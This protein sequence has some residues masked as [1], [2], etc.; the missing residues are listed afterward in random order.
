VGANR[1][2]L[3]RYFFVVLGLLVLVGGLGVV[4]ACQIRTLVAYGDDMKRAGPMPEAVGSDV[5]VAQ[6]WE[7]TRSA[8]GTVTGV[9]SV[10]VANEVAGIVTK[11]AF[12]S[13]DLVKAGQVLVELDVRDERAQLEAAEARRDLARLTAKRSRALVEAGA[14]PRSQL[15]QHETEL[16]AAESEVTALQAR[17]N[18]NVVRAPFD[19]R[20]GI[21]EVKLGQF[22]APGTRVTTI[23]SLGDVFVDFT[24]PQEQLQQVGVGY[25]VRV[26]VRGSPPITGT[27]SAIDPAVDPTTRALQLRARVPRGVG[28]LRTGMFVQVDVVLPERASVVV[29]PTTA[30]VHAPYGDSVFVVED[31]PAGEPGMRTAP[32]GRPVKIARQQFVRIGDSRG[33][34]TSIVQGLRAGQVVVSFG[35]F[36]LRNGSPIVIDNEVK[37]EASLDPQPEN[38]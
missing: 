35:A 6:S 17:V 20:A 4:K 29:V 25:P 24:L 12:E 16:A 19:G 28:G 37:P 23:D 9:E 31:K 2:R 10:E 8:V 21:R 30:I 3:R 27:I 36:K 13:G 11:L 7:L 33:D 15:D 34:F 22:L 38:R 5:A 32:D 14:V 26:T 18:N 1:H